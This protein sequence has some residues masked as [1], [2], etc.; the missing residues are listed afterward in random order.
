MR[1]WTETRSEGTEVGPVDWEHEWAKALPADFRATL[2]EAEKSPGEYTITPSDFSSFRIVSVCMYD[3]WPYWKPGPAIAY[4]GP[5]GSIEWTWFNSYGVR[6][7]CVR[8]GKPWSLGDAFA[9]S[10]CKEGG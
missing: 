3:G 9:P 10:G 4:V 6:P 5:L 1:T 7:G 2:Q 8:K